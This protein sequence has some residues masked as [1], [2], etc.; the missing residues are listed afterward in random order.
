VTEASRIPD[1]SGRVANPVFSRR[2]SGEQ[3]AA[4]IRSLIFHGQLRQGDRIRQDEL[5]AALGVSRI[6]V[7]EAIIALDREGWVTS[8][9]HRGAFVDGFD[10]A[11]VIDHYAMVGLLYGL[12]SQRAIE[13]GRDEQLERLVPLQKALQAAT[14]PDAIYHTNEQVIRQMFIAAG[15]PRLAAVSRV[16]SPVVPGNFFEAVPAAVSDQKRGIA[17]VVK[18]IVGRDGDRAAEEWHRLLARQGEHVIDL[19]TANNLFKKEK[20]AG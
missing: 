8:E 9:P 18:A 6:P 1:I 4:Y 5:A 16:M 14:A 10:R 19:L 12:T 15:S 7:R 3:V 11:G 2:S 17:K 13:R 20:P